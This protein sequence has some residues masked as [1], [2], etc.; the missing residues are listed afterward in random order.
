[1]KY[2]IKQ[3][4]SILGIT[5]NNLNYAEITTL[6]TDSRKI[7]NPSTTLFFA[8]ES[9]NNDAH[10][11]ISELYNSGV[12]NFVVSKQFDE[13]RDFKDANFLKVKNCLS[14][15]QKLA[16][17][18]RSKFDI[19]VIGITGSNGKTVVKEW[20]YQLLEKDFNIV[21]SPRSYNSQIGVPLSVW[22][23]DED[24]ELGI[25]PSPTKWKILS[26]LLSQLLV[27]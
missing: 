21:R 15:L 23:L 5:S 16:H 19:P 25:F 13:W 27:C 3:I 26:L 7:T 4:A 22:Q 14:T 24:T 6:L 9:K 12:R 11:Y 20:L 10:N 1:M 8:L 17:H 18:H 2:E